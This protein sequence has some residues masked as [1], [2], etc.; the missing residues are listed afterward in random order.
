MAISNKSRGSSKVKKTSRARSRSS[1]S[2]KAKSRSRSARRNRTRYSNSCSHRNTIDSILSLRK[3]PVIT[4]R[5]CGVIMRS[6]A[7][8]CLSVC[9]CLSLLCEIW[10]LKSLTQKLHF[11]YAGSTS[12]EYLGQVVWIRSRSRT[13]EQKSSVLF[14]FWAQT[15]ECFDLPTDFIL[16]L[17]YIF[18]TSR[19]RSSVKEMVDRLTEKV[20]CC[21][22]LVAVVTLAYVISQF[23]VYSSVLQCRV[24]ITFIRYKLTNN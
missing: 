14:G 13:Q 4:I 8:V 6:T 21:V 11:R 16:T 15:F 9:V 19:W 1:G 3:H 17:M 24:I 2:V 18:R 10:L 7:S 22:L 20:S 23:T 5:Q 12:L